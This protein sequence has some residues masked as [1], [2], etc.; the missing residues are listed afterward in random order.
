MD[1]DAFALM[2][3]V[4]WAVPCGGYRG[5]CQKD[6]L[7]LADLDHVPGVQRRD[8]IDQ[9]TVEM[10]AGQA[11]DVRQCECAVVPTDFRVPSTDGDV[12]EED[13]TIAE[14]ADGRDR[15]IQQEPRARVWTLGDD[16]NGPVAWP[17]ALLAG[18]PVGG[19]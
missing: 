12:I 6:Q 15:R 13:V 5:M 17:G 19:R 3:R 16:Q 11:A 9:L 10:G 8:G 18:I 1:A 2:A 7:T 14:P 4:D